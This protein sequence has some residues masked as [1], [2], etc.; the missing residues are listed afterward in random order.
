VQT[1]KQQDLVRSN[2]KPF[3]SKVSTIN[4]SKKDSSILS[5]P[6]KGQDDHAFFPKSDKNNTTSTTLAFTGELKN[7]DRFEDFG[8]QKKKPSPFVQEFPGEESSR[9]EFSTRHTHQP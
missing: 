1:Q 2:S 7:E 3:D 4:A 9:D 5:N 6:F 8:K